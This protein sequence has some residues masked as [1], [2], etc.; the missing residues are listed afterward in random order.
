MM[1]VHAAAEEDKLRFERE[2]KA[3]AK[4]INFHIMVMSWLP[5]ASSVESVLCGGFWI[6]D[7]KGC[8]GDFFVEKERCVRRDK[9]KSHASLAARLRVLFSTSM[10][11][12]I[13]REC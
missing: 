8:F 1:V 12:R 13:S 6:S 4:S 3:N 11:T 2:G 10:L 9:M 5:L 7:G